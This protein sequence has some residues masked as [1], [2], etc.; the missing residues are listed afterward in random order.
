MQNQKRYRRFP[1]CLDDGAFL[2]FRQ[3]GIQRE[4]DTPS[5]R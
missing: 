2:L 4:K 5:D 3:V 1:S